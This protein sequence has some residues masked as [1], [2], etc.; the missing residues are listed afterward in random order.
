LSFLIQSKNAWS[1]PSVK[2][3]AYRSRYGYP[4]RAER[5]HV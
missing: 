4:P 2:S 5:K 3:G 1:C